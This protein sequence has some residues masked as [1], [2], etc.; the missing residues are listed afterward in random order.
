MIDM[1]LPLLEDMP[2]ILLKNTKRKG[3]GHL[4]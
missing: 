3:R 2:E 1:I 4:V